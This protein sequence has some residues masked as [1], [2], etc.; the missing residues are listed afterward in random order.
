MTEALLLLFRVSRST[1]LAF[2]KKKKK[3]EQS[4]CVFFRLSAYMTLFVCFFFQVKSSF[5]FFSESI[6]APTF[7]L[8]LSTAPP[9]AIIGEHTF[10]AWK[11]LK[12][13]ASRFPPRAYTDNNG[14]G[15]FRFSLLLFL[16]F[17]LSLYSP[18]GVGFSFSL[19]SFFLLPLFLVP[20]THRLRCPLLLILSPFLFCFPLHLPFDQARPFS[21]FFLSCCFVLF[22]FFCS[23]TV[24]FY[25]VQS[26]VITPFF[27]FVFFF[28]FFLLS[29]ISLLSFSRHYH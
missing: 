5:F 10:N 28:W 2:W 13:R 29:E 1:F 15:Q 17:N 11:R 4:A 3:E 21:F 27:V 18:Y 23:P 20:W 6:V 22:F 26:L 24:F 25:S 7:F 16:F 14:K 8:F 9:F 12:Q 19:L